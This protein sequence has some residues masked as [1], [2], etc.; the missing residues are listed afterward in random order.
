[1]SHLRKNIAANLLSGGLTSVIA[2]AFIPLYLRFI[3]IEAYG[4]IG[5]FALLQGVLP[6]LDLGLSTTLN[7]EMARL[8]VHEGKQQEMRDILR[9]L[10][11]V[12][13]TVAGVI[14]IA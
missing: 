5:V 2:L 7:R 12:Y 8:S 6:L 1:M 14:A 3:S 10:E 11:L 13:W 9:T 4:L